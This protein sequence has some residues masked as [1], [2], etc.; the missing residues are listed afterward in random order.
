MGS[1]V[2]TE[3]QLS[4]IVKNS[5]LLV[6]NEDR[7]I[8]RL[9]ECKIS[10][11]GKYIIYRDN[12]YDSKTGDLVPLQEGW[13]LSDIL[14]GAADVASLAADFIIPGSGAIIDV[15]N[16]LSYI[17]EA[18]FVSDDKKDS[19]YL[20]AAITFAFVVL[21][22][23]L[24]AVATPL[25]RAVKT[26]AGFASKA[27][28]K[29]LKV[30]GSVLDSLLLKIPSYINKALKS[31]L[32][33]RI[34]GKA[35]GKISSFFQSFTTRIRKILAPLK[36]AGSKEGAE[37]LGK[38]G[39]KEVAGGA[40]QKMFTIKNCENMRLCN[41]KLIFQNFSKKLPANIPFNPAKV[42]VLQK[43]NIGG[44]EIAEVQLENGSKV[45]FYKSTGLGGKTLPPPGGW[46]VIPG[47]AENG[48]FIKTPETIGVTHTK[49]N[50]GG[51]NKY[52][53]DM[54][55]FLEKNGVN[56]LGKETAK[57]IVQ[58]GAKNV[59]TDI[60]LQT[61]KKFFSRIPK[62][63][64]GTKILRKAGFAPGF[65]YRYTS[66]KGAATTAKIMKVTD[67]GVLLKFKG[68]NEMMVPVET[69]IKNAVGAPWT[70]KG[71]G[72]TVPFFIKRFTD[73]LT[74]DGSDVD[75]KKIDQLK[76]LDPSQTSK[77]S[78]DYLQEEVSSYEGDEG[79]YTVSTNVTAFQQALELLGYMLE[80]AGAD[81]KFGPETKT[82]LE[83]F[84]KDNNLSSS[85]GKMDRYTAR[86]LAEKLKSKN[87]S[88]SQDLQNKL[89]KV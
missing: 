72:A 43:T 1:I 75:Y 28:V 36:N 11:N 22:G 33:K 89:N 6:M 58:K 10:K 61:A 3:E 40:F 82:Q 88:N 62:L 53:S 56:A 35:R 68:G 60:S 15:L 24:Q 77:E 76:D 27:V 86:K 47:F 65:A 64:Q 2:I 32:A 12:I 50:G 41:T 39:V 14:H 30:I 85:L 87:I 16:G 48:W 54:S 34:L 70:R 52:L 17:I 84:Q 81:G 51:T 20:M 57:K 67:N 38:K 25:K 55:Q 5:F 73:M 8:N 21:P 59:L 37:Q 42:K 63:S 26:G 79:N 46:S 19:L 83:K 23:P 69:F 80:K 74:S 31:P 49:I 18:Q 71:F 9:K 29:G 66:K 44:R 78:L 7:P 4:Y 13:S 45:L